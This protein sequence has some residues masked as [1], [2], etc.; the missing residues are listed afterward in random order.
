[1]FVRGTW[2]IGRI[3]GIEIAIHPSWLVIYALFAWSATVEARLLTPKLSQAAAIELGMVYALLLFASVVV[4]ELSHAIV[5]RRLGIPIGN[6]TLF[7]FGGVASINR[8]PG[9]PGDELRMAAAGPAASVVLSLLF[10]A[11]MWPLPDGWLNDLMYFLAI[12]NAALAAFNLLPAF[13]SDGGRI[14]RAI[15]WHFR[16]SQARATGTASVVSLFVAAALI[17]AGVYF[18]FNGRDITGSDSMA[19]KGGW[20]ILVGIF[21]AQAALASIRGSRVS[22]ILEEMPVAE[23]MAR[24]L[25]P[26]PTTTT[27]AGFVA[28]LAV[29]GRGAGYPVVNEGAFVGLVTLQDT[30]AVPH[31]LWQQTP[32][33][34]VMTPS[35]RT[36]FI[37]ST[38]PASD[39]LAALDEQHVGELPV[40]EGGSLTGVVSK[41]SIFT[42]L[43]AKEKAM[44]A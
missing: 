10:F 11:I 39:A 40:F 38:T 19:V 26:V 43:R 9:T 44:H 7:L 29:A 4:H 30:A 16:R 17:A 33:T 31:S 34:A 3:A 36:P 41:D 18:A 21:L 24:T 23:C 35:A 8:E 20:W 5:A 28:E 1:M 15:L 32:V 37:L 42:A 12:S 14:L 6:I 27:I 13:P 22:L 25:I 2:R